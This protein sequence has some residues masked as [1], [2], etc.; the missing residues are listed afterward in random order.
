MKKGSID[1]KR[2][3]VANHQTAEI[4]QPGERPLDHPAP[5]VASKNATILGRRPAPIQAE[6]SDQ[7]DAP[8]DVVDSR[9]STRASARR[10]AFP[11]GRQSEG[12]F[13]E[14]DRGRRP[15]PST[16]SPCPAW[17]FRLKRPF[18]RRSKTAIQERLAPLQLP[19]LVQLAQ[20]C[21]P[22][23]QPDALLLP[24]PQ[25]PPARRRMGIFLRQILPAS[26]A[27][28]DPEN[29]FQHATILYPRAATL[30][31]PGWFREQRRDFL[32]LR[33]GQ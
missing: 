8:L 32:P 24:I 27:P 3:I 19:A 23:F 31:R 26:T 4:P 15:P 12:S 1:R 14:E 5:F 33:F 10:V 17:F 30:A 28:Q 25:T 20:E 11:T 7:L 16:S 22:D 18:F 13:P 9:G 21:A 29:S 2:T 6:R